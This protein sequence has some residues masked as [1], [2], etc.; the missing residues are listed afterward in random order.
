MVARRFRLRRSHSFSREWIPFGSFRRVGGSDGG[1]LAK[2]GPQAPTL[3][4][5]GCLLFLT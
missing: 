5:P 3:T 1:F 4:S 2:L